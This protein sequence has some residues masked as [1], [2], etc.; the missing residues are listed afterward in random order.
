MTDDAV[1]IVAQR[2]EFVDIPLEIH[3]HRSHPGRCPCCQRTCYAPSPISIESRG[4][5][6]PR[7]T[8]VIA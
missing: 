2:V 3:V 1:P 4:L 6:G 8:T 7:P 5:A